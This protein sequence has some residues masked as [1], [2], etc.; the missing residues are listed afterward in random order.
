MIYGF[1]LDNDS[2]LSR[3]FTRKTGFISPLCKTGSIFCFSLFK[4]FISC[5]LMY[6]I[7]PSLIEAARQPSILIWLKRSKKEQ[8]KLYEWV[9]LIGSPSME[10]SNGTT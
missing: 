3:A 4:R 9:A 5:C 8:M 10:R 2:T 7:L 6:H 1:E